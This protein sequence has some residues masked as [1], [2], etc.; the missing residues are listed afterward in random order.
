MRRLIIGL[1]LTGALV[2]ASVAP[3]FAAKPVKTEIYLNN[4]LV[5]TIVPPSSSPQEGRDAFYKVEGGT[6]GVAAVGPGDAGYHGGQWAVYTVNFKMGV[7]PYVL[8]SE[9]DI[10]MAQS[11]GDVTIT[12]VAADDFKCPI[13][14]R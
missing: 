10:L 1:A 14:G 4:Q 5:R 13:R 9:A 6:T 2:V 11:D 3:T 12:R 7:T 8:T